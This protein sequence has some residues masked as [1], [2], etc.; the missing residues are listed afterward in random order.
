[1]MRCTIR[2]TAW[3]RI[4]A[5]QLRQRPPRAVL[6]KLMHRCEGS[7]LV[8]PAR[9]ATSFRYQILLPTACVLQAQ[10]AV[11]KSVS[12]NPSGISPA[13]METQAAADAPAIHF[14]SMRLSDSG[15]SGSIFQ[16]PAA[17]TL[18][19]GSSE[20]MCAFFFATAIIQHVPG[21]L[22]CSMHVYAAAALHVDHAFYCRCSNPLS[23]VPKPDS[24]IPQMPEP[25]E[26]SEPN[27]LN[28]PRP[29][30]FRSAGGT[31]AGNERGDK[32]QGIVRCSQA[33]ARINRQEIIRSIEELPEPPPNPV[34]LHAMLPYCVAGDAGSPRKGYLD[35]LQ[36]A[37]TRTPM[38]KE[39]FVCMEGEHLQKAREY[40][41]REIAKRIN[42]LK[43]N[44]GN[45]DADISHLS[46][47]EYVEIM[48]KHQDNMKKQLKLQLVHEL[49]RF[50]DAAMAR[51]AHSRL[52][53]ELL[54]HSHDH[55]NVLLQV[56]KAADAVTRHR[57]TASGVCMPSMLRSCSDKTRWP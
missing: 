37:L 21:V 29:P 19:R 5:Y 54:F 33:I 24:P 48:N 30:S 46:D 55:T 6:I 50:Q 10:S 23:Y 13:Q 4:T 14:T 9:V 25:V 32:Y 39:E 17:Q 16:E 38:T 7:V 11:A 44:T 27:E 28:L 34:L 42:V 47:N 53:Q 8:L 2:V 35:A 45:S 22:Q 1:M 43:A 57:R 49:G 3:H 20:S 12:P 40:I 51:K 41:T 31:G 36:Y 56:A 26:E 52:R 15:T 18:R